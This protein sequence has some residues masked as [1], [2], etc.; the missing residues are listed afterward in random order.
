LG[1]WVLD[2][3]PL[4]L[5]LVG[6]GFLCTATIRVPIYTLA[7]MIPPLLIE[8]ARALLTGEPVVHDVWVGDL[9]YW[10]VVGVRVAMCTVFVGAVYLMACIPR[11]R[12]DGA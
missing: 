5:A 8:A 4:V 2:Y 1:W 3:A 11:L 6:A 12:R 9:E 7:F 10:L